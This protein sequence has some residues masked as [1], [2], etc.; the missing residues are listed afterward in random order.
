MVG[1]SALVIIDVINEIAH[2]D[3]KFPEVCLDYVQKAGLIPKVGEAVSRARNAE[4]QVIWV[5]LEFDGDYSNVPSYSQVL[6]KFLTV[7]LYALDPGGFYCGR[8]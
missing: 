3:G 2:P 7:E 8:A 5:T 4:L 6:R 1:K